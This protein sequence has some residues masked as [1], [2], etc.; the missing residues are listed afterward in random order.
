MWNSHVRGGQIVRYSRDPEDKYVLQ[1]LRAVDHTCSTP[2]KT[3][4]PAEVK[5][6]E[7]KRREYTLPFDS[8]AHYN[9]MVPLQKKEGNS[10]KFKISE[11][12]WRGVNLYRGW[13]DMRLGIWVSLGLGSKHI[14][15]PGR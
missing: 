13:K 8:V 10:P 11:A 7:S 4:E 1:N 9:L 6:S 3:A 2:R 12:L 15:S 5:I 14:L